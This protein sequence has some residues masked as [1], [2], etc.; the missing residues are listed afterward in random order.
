[1]PKPKRGL[2]LPEGD[3]PE[4]MA[5]LIRDYVDSMRSR[6]YSEATVLN[7]TAYLRRFMTWC[8][9]RGL[10]R[11]QEITRPILE[12]YQRSLYHY[13]RPNGQPISFRSQ[14]VQLTAIRGFFRYLT[15]SNRI[16]SNPGSDLELP[17]V[18]LR[19][20]RAV[21]TA[22]EAEQVLAKPDLQDLF[23][24]RDRALLEVLYSC[25]LRRKEVVNLSL[26]DLDQERGTLHVRQGKGKKDRMVPI[27]ERALAWVRKYLD[28]ARPKLVVE[29]DSGYLFLTLYGQPLSVSWLTD[30]V[31]DYVERSGVGK[32]GSCHLFRHTMA[33]L[34]LEGGADI[35]FIQE[36][37]GHADPKTTQIYT[38][39]SIKKLQAVH[40]ATHPGA[41][42]ER[43][44]TANSAPAP[45]S[46]D[47]ARQEEAREELL[48]S[49]AVEAA[50]E[51][52]VEET[53]ER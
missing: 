7:R 35:R 34:M 25:G 52:A 19:L 39:V 26:Y 50:D 44:V 12:R 17:K 21:L 47:E 3:D 9:D 31:R 14:A 27:G 5:L 13:R 37:L 30:R 38:L 8:A 48:S 11:P 29:P 4:G 1:M 24:L 22:S 49:L 46:E 10:T 41:K 6:N 45:A 23:G 32:H 20:P 43:A 15:R 2:R 36:M 40:A 18:E 28:E 33:T 53:K 51:E 16:L 42:L